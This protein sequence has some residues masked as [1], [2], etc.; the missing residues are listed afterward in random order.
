VS[1]TRYAN[2]MTNNDN[3]NNNMDFDLSFVNIFY[4]LFLFLKDLKMQIE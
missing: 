2:C 3:H 1:K 4:D